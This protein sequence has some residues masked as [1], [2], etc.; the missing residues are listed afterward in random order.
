MLTHYFR[1]LESLNLPQFIY[2]GKLY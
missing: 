2:G 1:K